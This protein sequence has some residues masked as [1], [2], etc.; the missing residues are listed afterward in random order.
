MIKCLDCKNMQSM[1][2]K[3]KKKNGA[4]IKGINNLC[5]K[6]KDIESVSSLHLCKKFNEKQ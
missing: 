4:W 6:G 2:F 3:Y 5:L 1:S